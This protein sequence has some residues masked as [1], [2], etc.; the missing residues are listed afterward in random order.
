MLD[1]IEGL[2]DASAGDDYV[3]VMRSN[4]ATVREGQGCS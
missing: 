4:L 2:T 3:S 1:P